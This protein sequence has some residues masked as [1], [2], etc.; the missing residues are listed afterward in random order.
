MTDPIEEALAAC[1]RTIHHLDQQVAA[2]RDANGRLTAQLIETQ[3]KLKRVTDELWA[4]RHRCD[5]LE[6]LLTQY[7][8]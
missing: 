2:T 7:G 3:I 5:E 1:T 4:T 6:G 8:R